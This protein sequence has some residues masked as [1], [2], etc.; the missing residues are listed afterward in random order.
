MTDAAVNSLGM[1]TSAVEQ[2]RDQLPEVAARTVA[3]VIAEV[4]S[5]ATALDGR[6]GATIAEAV[7]T[8][9]GGF[10]VVAVRRETSDPSAPLQPAL[11]AAYGLGRGEARAGRTVFALLAAYRVGARVAWRE[12]AA[13]AVTAGLPGDTL[14]RFAE[15]VFAYIDELS[16]ASV[17]GH[18]DELA[19]SDRVRQRYRDRLARALLGREPVDVLLA[20]AARAEWEPPA[21]LTVVV[22]PSERSRGW[23][24]LTDRRWLVLAG[25]V[26]GVEPDVDLLTCLVPDLDAR[27]RT[28]LLTALTGRRAV[29]GPA[30]PWTEV[31]SSF[32]RA[33]RA[34]DLLDRPGG[35]DALDTEDHLA[36][37][38]ATADRDTLAD[39]RAQVLAPLADLRPAAAEKLT[40]TLR[41]WLLHHGRREEVAAALFVHPQTVR[42]R[43]T[44]LRELYGDR[45]EDPATVFALTVALGP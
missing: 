9:L 10:L 21:T 4:P 20:A 12:M 45:L 16:A 23:R 5:Y 7:Q 11:D 41:A 25:D 35:E 18:A 39:L 42:Y 36:T 6:M 31:R 27:G 26:P 28:D 33:L 2:L 32:E 14:A 8:A 22:L 1:T 43:M 40:E 34:R 37:L 24:A 30:R 13:V 3:A 17:S 15:L 38:V 29:V 19:A 44:Q